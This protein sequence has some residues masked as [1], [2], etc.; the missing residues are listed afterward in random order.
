MRPRA[1]SRPWAPLSEE[2]PVALGLALAPVLD[3]PANPVSTADCEES[4]TAALVD[5]LVTGAV[6][7]VVVVP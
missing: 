7:K 3:A 5:A 4:V 6:P 1:T 2:D